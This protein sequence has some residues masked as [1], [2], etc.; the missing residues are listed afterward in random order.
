MIKITVNLIPKE[1]KERQ[2]AQKLVTLAFVGVV[3]VACIMAALFAF[4][5][6]K[7]SMAE[8]QVAMM[9]QQADQMNLAIQ[10]LGIYEQ[11]VN[12]LQQKKEIVNKALGDKVAWSKILEQVMVVT[13]DNV[14]LTSL[15]GNSD[16]I[17]FAGSVLDPDDNPDIG[18]KPVA[19]WLTKLSD[20]EPKPVVWLSSSDKQADTINFT[21]TAK[22]EKL[23]ASSAPP[24]TSGK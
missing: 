19:N 5:T 11:R 7:I 16:G 15:S 8:S 14:S 21:N 13:P 10:R 22:F 17:T 23:P 2:K 9:K 6:W 3:M 4:N 12:E 1:T 24:T 20:I 18:H